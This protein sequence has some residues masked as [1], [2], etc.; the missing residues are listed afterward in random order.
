MMIKDCIHGEVEFQF[1]RAGNLYYKCYNGFEFC[2]PISDTDG[3]TFPAKDKGIFFMRW[4]RKELS[5]QP[6][7]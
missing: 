4:I 1:Y 3:A 5:R 6:G 7:E 2:V